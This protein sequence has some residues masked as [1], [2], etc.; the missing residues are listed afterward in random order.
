MEV[1]EP[2][3]PSPITL[4][5]VEFS[6]VPSASVHSMLPEF[7]RVGSFERVIR[8]VE[9]PCGR[10]A[11]A[12]CGPKKHKRYVAHF[13]NVFGS[14][15][16]VRFITL[17]LDGK[18]GLLPEDSRAYLVH[19]WSRWR[20]RINRR[21]DD[22]ARLAYVAAVEHQKETGQ[23]HLHAVVS[24][25]GVD[26]IELGAAWY[27]SGGGVVVDVQPIDGE[28]DAARYVGYSVKYALKDAQAGTPAG[29][30][31]LSSQ[32]DGYHSKAHVAARLA[33]VDAAPEPEAEEGRGRVWIASAQNTGGR[34]PQSATPDQ[35]ERFKQLAL[36]ERTSHYHF[37]DADG[38]WWSVLHEDGRRV[39]LPGYRSLFDCRI[40]ASAANGP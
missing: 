4:S 31:V 23:A 22:G 13:V 5:Q 26:D 1:P 38:R 12:V 3:C 36:E 8:T 29:R 33:H 28:A 27:E 16:S 18:I 11:C 19:C 20:K 40:A 14:M 15:G 17:T 25:P 30:Y 39:E 9:K 21:V 35:R 7:E 6:Y 37:K 34:E 10:W 2:R 32:G 24:A